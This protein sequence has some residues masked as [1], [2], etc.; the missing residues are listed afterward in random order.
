MSDQD[1]P[2]PRNDADAASDT[3]ASTTTDVANTDADTKAEQT[4]TVEDIG[5]ARKRMVIEIP[6]SRIAE[7]IEKAYGTLRNDAVLP[8]FRRGRAPRR[9]LEKRFGSDVRN[10]V[11]GQ[12]IGESYSQAIEEQGIEVIGEPD[13]K[14]IETLELPESGPLSFTVEAEVSPEV[15][16]P[17]LDQLE[18]T[19][20]KVEVTDADI[21]AEVVELCKRFGGS[22][23]ATE[24][25]V[26]QNDNL[27]VSVKILAGEDAGDEAELLEHRDEAY[28]TVHGEAADF[29]GHVAGIVVDD[30]GKQ[31][32]EK[33]VGDTVTISMTGPHYHENEKI[34]K[35]PITLVITITGI[36]RSVPLEPAVLAERIG[37]E[38]EEEVR[39]WISERLENQGKQRQQTD[40]FEQLHKQLLEKVSMELPEDLTSKQVER[41]LQRKRVEL[42]MQGVEPDEAENKLAEM[43]SGSEKEAKDEL[44]LYFILDKASKQLEVEVTEGEINGRIVQ[45]AM[46]RNRR[47]EKLRQELQA[48]GELDQLFLKTREYK[49]LMQI[50]EKAKVEEIDEVIKLRED[51][52]EQAT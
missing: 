44:K 18:V 50:L 29:K 35:Q 28:A 9:L 19:K 5:P 2:T 6:E 8:G 52:D 32:I 7:Q 34:R 30:L 48:S 40:L 15:E 36:E 12:L 20:R 42:Y 46:E 4:V 38:S 14:D 22:E 33:Q 21:D 1:T 43:R 25:K 17:P 51:D 47:P 37:A 3:D 23:I 27:Q 49:T 39:K 31:L 13:V 11:K 24:G 41:A 45:I 16:L 10:D 26:A